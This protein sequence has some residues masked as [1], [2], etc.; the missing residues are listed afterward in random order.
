[1]PLISR[2]KNTFE[3]RWGAREGAHR[4][5][6]IISL[7]SFRGTKKSLRESHEDEGSYK[8]G[9][10]AIFNVVQRST[11][12]QGGIAIGRPESKVSNQDPASSIRG[13]EA[14]VRPREDERRPEKSDAGA[15]AHR[16]PSESAVRPS[17][18]TQHHLP[19]YEHPRGGSRPSRWT[20]ARGG[21]R[22]LTIGRRFACS[23]SSD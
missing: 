20:D 12:H 8:R 23:G 14:C 16:Q 13:R 2:G 3:G 22:T 9:R 17:G 15:G 4:P 21:D 19:T 7:A 11:S 18:G 6:E 10:K 1:M 5:E